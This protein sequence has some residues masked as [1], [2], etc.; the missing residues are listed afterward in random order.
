MKEFNGPYGNYAAGTFGA[1]LN[2]MCEQEGRSSGVVSNYAL[3][4]NGKVM[5]SPSSD[6]VVATYVWKGDEIKFTWM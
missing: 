3:G 4:G 2:A 5:A 6:K 1:V